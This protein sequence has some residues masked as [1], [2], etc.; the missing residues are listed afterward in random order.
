MDIANFCTGLQHIG[1]PTENLKET[2][3]F[4]KSL[5]FDTVHTVSDQFGNSTVIFLKFKNLVIET[6]KSK[7]A[8]QETGAINHFAIDTSDIEEAFRQISSSGFDMIDKEI[9]FLPFWDKGFRYFNIRGINGEII[10][11]GQIL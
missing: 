4:Y 1:I 11:F 6:Y 7:E 10:E 9:R 3:A 5:G 2:E 8:H